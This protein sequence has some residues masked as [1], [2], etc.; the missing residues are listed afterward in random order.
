MKEKKNYLLKG[1]FDPVLDT[2]TVHEEQPTVLELVTSVRAEA[3]EQYPHNLSSKTQLIVDGVR[4]S[5]AIVFKD[6]QD[7]YVLIKR[8]TIESN[9]YNND[10]NKPE[11]L[12]SLQGYDFPLASRGVLP[13]SSFK[14][15]NCLDD[16]PIRNIAYMGIAHEE[17]EQQNANDDAEK[18]SMPCYEA[19]ID[20]KFVDQAAKE[21][22]TVLNKN[23][24]LSLQP[25][26]C[27][28]KVHVLKKYIRDRYNDLT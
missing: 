20:E 14:V 28:S 16:A 10:H 23:A 13:D 8:K 24:I 17:S 22:G 25:Q 7:R 6:T 26:E 12:A 19:T 11:E 9:P 15:H 18:V 5:I 2:K 4:H 3:H 27:S 21:N 1:V